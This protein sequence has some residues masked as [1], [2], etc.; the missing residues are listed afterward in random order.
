MY[1]RSTTKQLISIA[2]D[3]MQLHVHIHVKRYANETIVR[4]FVIQ[5]LSASVILN[6]LITLY[7][8]FTSN[9]HTFVIIYVLRC[10]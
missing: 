6:M 7:V 8:L 2:N 1:F 10:T 4:S 3:D 5:D 9:I